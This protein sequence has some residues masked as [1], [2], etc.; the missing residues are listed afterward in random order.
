M[1]RRGIRSCV[2]VPSTCKSNADHGIVAIDQELIPKEEM[3]LNALEASWSM[4]ATLSLPL[5]SPLSLHPYLSFS[6]PTFPI[7]FFYARDLCDLVV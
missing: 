3:E 2:R 6:S 5:S 4:L 1:H 7:A